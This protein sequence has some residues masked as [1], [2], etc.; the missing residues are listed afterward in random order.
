MRLSKKYKEAQI[1]QAHCEIS[2]TAVLSQS[3][4]DL[5]PHDAECLTN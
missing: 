4:I 1:M 5:V 3:A 2:A